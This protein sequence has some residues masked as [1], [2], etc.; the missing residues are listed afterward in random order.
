MNLLDVAKVF[1][2]V[3]VPVDAIDE[4]AGDK[5][6]HATSLVEP[7]NLKVMAAE[8]DKDQ[9]T[10]SKEIPV[11]PMKSTAVNLKISLLTQ[12]TEGAKAEKVEALL[13]IEFVMTL[14]V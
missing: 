13:S 7:C 8:A 1:E 11:I 9:L 12:F 2:M 3:N 4:T 6:V 10:K 14:V 5:S